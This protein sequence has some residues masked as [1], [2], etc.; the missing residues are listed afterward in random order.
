M[1]GVL[2]AVLFL[3]PFA[4]FVAWRLLS[5]HLPAVAVW[6][7]V[8]AVLLIGAAGAWVAQRPH[9]EHGQGYVPPTWRDGVVVPGHAVPR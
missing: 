4:A 7:A 2:E 9:L 1:I 3:T 8:A 6:V 5:P